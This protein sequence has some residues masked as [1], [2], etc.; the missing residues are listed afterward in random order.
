M[1]DNNFMFRNH[2]S[3]SLGAHSKEN[4]LALVLVFGQYVLHTS[5]EECLKNLFEYVNH[6]ETRSRVQ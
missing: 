5:A 2:E 6:T 4:L 1:F 3:T